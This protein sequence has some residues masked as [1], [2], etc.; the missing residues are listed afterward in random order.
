MREDTDIASGKVK[1]SPKEL[2]QKRVRDT[3][4]AQRIERTRYRFCR[5]LEGL[6][7]MMK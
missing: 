6:R 1:M 4:E 3:A 5:V 7:L 2:Q